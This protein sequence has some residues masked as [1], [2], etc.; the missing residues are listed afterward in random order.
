MRNAIYR[1]ALL[2]EET[3]TI[4]AE[5]KPPALLSTCSEIRDEAIG[6]WHLEQKFTL[7]IPDCNSDLASKFMA[8][9]WRYA[10]A[11]NQARYLGPS[12]L[13]GPN[14]TN[15][16]KWCQRINT[17]HMCA[18]GI[19]THNDDMY[20]I[21][22]AATMIAHTHYGHEWAK[23]EEALVAFRHVAGTVDAQWLQD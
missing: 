13:G 3:T 18:L 2:S 19:A 17:G 23:C 7:S 4:T 1:F 11:P 6:I 5:L 16:M 8:M 21:V 22:G 14:W 9:S 10:R 20:K 15:L 12:D